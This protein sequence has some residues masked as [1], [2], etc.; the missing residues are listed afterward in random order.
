M[1]GET[2]ICRAN[3]L[4]GKNMSI[5]K[6]AAV[7]SLGALLLSGCQTTKEELEKA[8]K[9]PLTGAQLSARYSQGPSY[10]FTSSQGASGKIDYAKNGATNVKVGDFEDTGKWRIK[11]DTV[12][13][14]WKKIRDGKEGCF[15]IYDLGNGKQRSLNS[16]GNETTTNI[17]RVK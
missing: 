15:T 8:G 14:T 2:A 5:F 6:F 4:R 3:Q 13:I 12:C 11:G 10:T 17:K 9:A 7:I 1:S 16:D